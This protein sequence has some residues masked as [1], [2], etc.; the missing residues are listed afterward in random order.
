MKTLTFYYRKEFDYKVLPLTSLGC[1]IITVHAP[2]FISKI[3]KVLNSETPEAPRTFFGGRGV[4]HK[5]PQT[6]ILI[7]AKS[8]IEN[9]TN[10]ENKGRSSH[11]INSVS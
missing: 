6:G 7:T 4:G 3:Q 9:I 2:Y 1:Y 5:V 10:I 8:Y 11:A